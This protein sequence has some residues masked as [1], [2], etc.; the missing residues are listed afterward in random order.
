MSTT[1]AQLFQILTSDAQRD[2]FSPDFPNSAVFY[3]TVV[4]R[5]SGHGWTVKFDDLPSEDN[6]IKKIKRDTTAAL[7]KREEKP[8]FNT[9]YIL[10]LEE[11]NRDAQK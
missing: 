9:K 2:A 3:G 1:R 4:G 8:R 7:G 10:Q 6:E 11:Q 5:T